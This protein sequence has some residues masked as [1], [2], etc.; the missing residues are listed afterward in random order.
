MP[1]RPGVKVPMGEHKI[2]SGTAS[3][4]GW[5]LCCSC[6]WTRSVRFARW[7]FDMRVVKA[8]RAQHHAGHVRH[9]ALVH[10]VQTHSDRNCGD[11]CIYPR[12]PSEPALT[13]ANPDDQ[14]RDLR[15]E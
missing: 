1:D 8:E 10:D 6:G 9:M 2:V 3:D 4:E 7:V 12:V 11:L 13:G 14:Q 5:T 15:P